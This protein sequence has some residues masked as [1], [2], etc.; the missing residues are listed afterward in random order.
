MIWET[1]I[2][3]ETHV[4]LS[5]KTKLFCPCSTR[6]GGEPNTQCCPVCMGLPGA[7]PALNERALT[8]AVRTGL[9]LGGEITRRCHF[10]RKHYFYPDL[11]KAY[12]ISQ[13][14]LPIVRGGEVRI[15]GEGGEE[16]PIHIHEL[17]L[18]EDAGKLLH[19]PQSGQTHCDYNRSGVPLIE[20]VTEPDF[21]TAREVVAYLE[22]LRLM[23]QYLGVSDGKMQEGSLRCDINLS[24]R[25]GG[26]R[27]LGT[28]TEM[29]NISSF[30]AV[31]RA[32]DAE[33]RRQIAVL[34]AGGRVVQETR[35]WDE[36][37]ARSFSLRAKEDAQDY[38]YF[39][40]PD[41][42][43][44]EVTE[45]ELERI[46]GELP[47]LA[48]EKT[49][50]YQ[51]T[52]GLPCDDARML[53]GQRAL[54]EFFEEVVELGAPPRQAANWI[55]REVL[56]R[57]SAGRL[58][59]RDMA[60]QPR[61]L[62]RLIAM[63]EEGRLNRN[64]AVEVFDAVFAEDGDIDAYVEEHGLEQVSDRTLV[65]AAA[66]RVLSANPGP[67]SDVRG[68]KEKALGF[69]VGQVMREMGGRASP[70]VVQQVLRERL[71][72]GRAVSPPSEGR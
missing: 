20:I 55:L 37:R 45:A 3:L 51:S 35:G 24:V 21:R 14:D 1:V 54:A 43:P 31:A 28:R 67:V 66:E 19:D 11:P 59:A 13:R 53:T 10:D 52:W 36:D 34:E 38:R 62:A 33:A 44:L 60:L 56:R 7:L 22:K 12:Q 18:E 48:E 69:L 57:L 26:S 61:T 6:F 46:R 15:M 72:S 42:P 64:T 71:E 58:E 68:G 27:E 16:R 63:V 17:H 25:P 5:T 49:A 23:L 30:K 9:A 29:K 70:Q 65:T 50:R 47:E 40:E 41:L 39:P 32:V 4:E 8:Y 2:G